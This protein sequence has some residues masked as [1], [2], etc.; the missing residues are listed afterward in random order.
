[1]PIIMSERRTVRRDAI[2]ET[3]ICWEHRSGLRI[4]VIPKERSAAFAAVTVRF[5][6]DDVRYRPE[7]GAAVRELP[8]GVAHFLE[9][10]MF[11]EENG[12]DAFELYAKTGADANAFTAHDRTCYLFSCTDNFETNLRILLHSVTHPYFTE[13][14]VEK[15]KK[16]I[17]EEIGMYEDN[18]EAR[19]DRGLM[20]ALYRRHPIRSDVL[21]TKES[22]AAITPELLYECTSA[23]YTPRNMF[24]VVAG[25]VSPDDVERVCDEVLPADA[26]PFTA[27]RIPAEEPDS[28]A[29]ER[30]VTSFPVAQPLVSIGFKSPAP[31]SSEEDMLFSAANAV[32]I[33]LLFGRSGDFFN[34][35][36]ESGLISE[37]FGA[38]Y[39]TEIG[40][41]YTEV[42]AVCEDP[43]ALLREVRAEIARRRETYFTEEEFDS[44]RRAVY[45][46]CLFP[47]DS[48]EDTALICS[49]YLVRGTDYITWPE[50]VLQL[51]RE[52]AKA[53]LDRTIDPDRYAVSIL[54]PGR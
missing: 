14:S 40:C 26:P 24:L 44:A 54:L 37:R 38:Y 30:S 1:M 50:T 32:N 35:L 8:E 46:N 2:D 23:F 49:A 6:A 34:R 45:A 51:T 33:H 16:I 13:E 29:A 22:I 53:V 36:Y 43:D 41:A 31:A 42:G 3:Y 28:I 48:V 10:K 4:F 25:T 47:L 20:R 27:E 11:A 18:P 7:K 17:A 9:H 15:E 21:G 39:S 12:I 19:V 52:Q 5:G